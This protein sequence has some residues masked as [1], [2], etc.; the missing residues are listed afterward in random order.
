MPQKAVAEAAHSAN[1]AMPQP[2]SVSCER[3]PCRRRIHTNRAAKAKCM[4]LPESAC[5][6]KSARLNPPNSSMAFGISSGTSTSAVR[7]PCRQSSNQAAAVHNAKGSGKVHSGA[8]P[9]RLSGRRCSRFTEESIVPKNARSSS[10]QPTAWCNKRL[11]GRAVSR[12][13]LL[14]LFWLRSGALDSFSGSHASP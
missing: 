12:C 1:A 14:R 2:R 11:N 10:S 4:R 3:K 13:C 7:L 6:T 8:L 9:A 5:A